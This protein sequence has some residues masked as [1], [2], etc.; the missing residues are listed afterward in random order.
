MASGSGIWAGRR[1]CLREFSGT[2]ASGSTRR[3][4]WSQTLGRIR[5]RHAL[6]AE[7]ANLAAAELK[8]ELSS[9]QLKVSIDDGSLAEDCSSSQLAAIN[10][11][12]YGEVQRDLS[13]WTLEKDAGTTVLL[14]DLAKKELKS[15]NGLWKVGMSQQRKQ[16]FGWNDKSKPPVKKASE[17]LVRIAPGAPVKADK[18]P[19][20][21]SRE[22]LCVG[23]DDGQDEGHAILRIH[24]DKEVVE[25]L[26][27]KASLASLFGV[28]VM[29]RYLKIFIRGDE[30]SPILL[31]ELGGACIPEKTT[32]EII[33]APIPLEEG[34]PPK[35]PPEV[36]MALQVRVVKA[37]TS[38]KSWQRVL[39]ENPHALE[40]DH[41]PESLEDLHARATR[42]V[43]PDRSGW[44]PE[45][46]KAES[47]AKADAC[48][49][50][51][52]WRDA[53]VFYTRAISHTPEDH[54]L[55]S[56]RSA[57]YMKI[58]KYEKALADARKC[59]S[60][61]QSWAK[62]YFRQGQALRGLERW[63]DSRSAF[64]EG[65]FL[66]PENPEWD[67]E[68]LKTDE[69][70][71]KIDAKLV[72]ER[73]K[74]READM[75]TELNESTVVAEREA[76]Q[77]VTAAAL[78]LGKS[79]KEAGE[80]ALKGAE[81][82][83]QRVHEMAKQKEKAMVL[84]DD[85]ELDNPPPYRIVCEDGTLHGK[86]F[87]HTDKGQY[88]MGMVM[89]NYESQPV[90]QPWVEIRH[91]GKLRWSQGCSL[92]RLRVHLPNSVKSAADLDV[93]VTTTG[94]RVGTVGDADAVVEGNFDRK[95]E[96]EGENFSW[97]LIP[98][99]RPPMLEMCID[100]DQ[101]ELYQTFSYGTLLWERLFDDDVKLGEG[102]FEADLTDLPEELR[103]KWARQQKESNTRSYEER[104]RR[105]RMTEE[106]IMEETARNWNDEFAKHGMSMRLDTNEELKAL[107]SDRA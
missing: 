59:I 53:S 45:M 9:W 70:Q 55:Y 20:V 17:M 67:K 68:I 49:K 44:T 84:E 61:N 62:A 65:R 104:T 25:N 78:K 41:A 86:G 40:R 11:D 7:V 48:F 30:R 75:T 14:V 57:C 97:Y 71:A 39:T 91:P 3:V 74:K 83:K 94:I 60:L 16:H 77:H 18:D 19:F 102:L 82:A 54:K 103:E 37:V 1:F 101:S 43:S 24:L 29:E 92:I 42:P 46:H 99:E 80:L 51:S 105:K 26:K 21:V 23:L 69:E 33:K 52:E 88:F 72:E 93:S 6:P 66:D 58:R 22:T 107:R 76:M 15:W 34:E 8:V 89:M 28:D 13:W 12:L 96:P 5:L 32:M 79:R 47:K 98:D 95:V 87:A 4:D 10:G 50:K 90:N 106:E 38:S 36:G 81:L 35:S 27:E 73:K 85:G 31:G 100:K 64:S 56:N 2:P 63:D